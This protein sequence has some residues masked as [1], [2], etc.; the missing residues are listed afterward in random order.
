VDDDLGHHTG[1]HADGSELH[2][3]PWRSVELPAAVAEAMTMLSLEERRLLYWLAREYFAGIGAIVDGGSFVGGST[4]ALGEGLRANHRAQPGP[5]IH[6]FDKFEVNPFMAKQI[7]GPKG[8][9]Y[10]PGD[11]FRPLFDRQTA[12]VRDL[13][14]VHAGDLVELGWSGGPIEILFID[15]AKS[16]SLNDVI[17][18]QFFPNLVPGRSV[19]VQQDLVFSLY[20][21]LA[22]TMEHLHEEFQPVAFVEYNSVVYLCRRPVPEGVSSSLRELTTEQR[23]ELMDRAVDRFRGY[24]RGLLLLAKAVLLR[25]CGFDAEAR[26]EATAVR[27]EYGDHIAVAYALMPLRGWLPEGS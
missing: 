19:V 17:V 1:P 7:F 21:W 16:W 3:H 20:P 12:A 5:R 25:N 11:S 26:A 10:A 2:H 4:V 15:I 24:P 13:L 6:V 9:P 8:L 18:D 22:L 23:L 27:R 14:D